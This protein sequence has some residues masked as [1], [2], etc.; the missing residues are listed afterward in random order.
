MA[1]YQVWMLIAALM[2]HAAL[3]TPNPKVAIPAWVMSVSFGV[4]AV[5]KGYA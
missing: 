2:G 4:M 1:D 5:A 3:V